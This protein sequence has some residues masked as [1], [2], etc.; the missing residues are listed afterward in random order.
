MNCQ[1]EPLDLLPSRQ[2]VLLYTLDRIHSNDGTF[3]PLHPDDLKGLRDWIHAKQV[4]ERETRESH[5]RMYSAPWR[6][7]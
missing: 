5:L 6:V 2:N 3:G 1:I 4:E 7:G